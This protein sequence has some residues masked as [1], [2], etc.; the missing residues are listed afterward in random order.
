MVNT[1]IT[2]GRRSCGLFR[3]KRIDLVASEKHE[4]LNGDVCASRYRTTVAKRKSSGLP[5]A[6]LTIYSKASELCR[7]RS[8]TSR[9][10]GPAAEWIFLST[11]KWASSARRSKDSSI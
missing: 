2:L 6:H 1:P 4:R 5:I 8:R 9:G 3:I 7:Y 10:S 11:Q